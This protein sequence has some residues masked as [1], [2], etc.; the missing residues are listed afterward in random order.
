MVH[1][2]QVSLQLQIRTG[3][4]LSCLLMASTEA[5]NRLSNASEMLPFLQIER[6]NTPTALDMTDTVAIYEA[7]S[8][9]SSTKK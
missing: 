5:L 9:P 7:G 4:P 6:C 3:L 1:T 8:R 2:R